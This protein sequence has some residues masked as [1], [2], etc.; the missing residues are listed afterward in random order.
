VSIDL[1][2][3]WD[4]IQYLLRVPEESYHFIDEI[5]KLE[6]D[7]D[8]IAVYIGKQDNKIIELHLDYFGRVPIRKIELFMENDTI[9]CDLIK[10]EILY[11]KN[12]D[13]INFEENRD[14]YQKKEL[15]YFLDMVNAKKKI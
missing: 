13:S 11:L 9:I 10:N 6:M 14:D 2:H 12:K 4:Y 15:V 1:I 5:S 3:E 7:S 8:D